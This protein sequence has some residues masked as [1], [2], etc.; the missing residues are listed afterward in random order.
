MMRELVG[1]RFELGEG[2]PPVS[3][4]ERFAVTGDIDNRLEDVGEVELH[5]QFRS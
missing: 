2:Q 1:T 5:G 3:S 4:D